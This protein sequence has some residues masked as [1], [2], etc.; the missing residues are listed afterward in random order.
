MPYTQNFRHCTRFGKTEVINS[1]KSDTIK[2]RRS[3]FCA[4]ELTFSRRHDTMQAGVSTHFF[5][6]FLGLYLVFIWSLFS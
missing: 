5:G 3:S 6:R 2:T 1:D 4:L